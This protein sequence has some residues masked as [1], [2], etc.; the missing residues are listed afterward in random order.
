MNLPKLGPCFI[1][2]FMKS[3]CHKPSTYYYGCSILKPI[4]NLSS[5]DKELSPR[6]S[7]VID[8][9]ECVQIRSNHEALFLTKFKFLQ[10]SCC[11][12]FKK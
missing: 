3:D 8:F 2:V 1:G 6:R 12:P 11:N 5:T 7:G 4:E 10:K 9:E